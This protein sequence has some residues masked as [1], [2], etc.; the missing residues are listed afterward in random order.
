MDG[1]T[2]HNH[3]VPIVGGPL[4]GNS[5]TMEGI[6]LPNSVPMFYEGKFYNY[7]LTVEQKD[8]WTCVY[9]QYSNETQE[10]NAPSEL[11]PTTDTN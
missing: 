11:P 3:I 9:Y 6:S 2:E 5:M 10:I 7:E 8:Y 1:P 4:C